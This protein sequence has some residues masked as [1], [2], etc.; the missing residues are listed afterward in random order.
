MVRR[1]AAEIPAE[2]YAGIAEVVVSPRTVRHPEREGIW[3]LGECIPLPGED[4]DP[5]H[6]QSRVVLYHGSFQALARETPDFDWE[7]EAWETLTHEVRHHVEWKARAPDLDAY[8]RAAEAN[9][10][11][12]DGEP[13]D[14]LFFR[15]GIPLPDGSYQVDDDVFVERVVAAAPHEVELRWRGEL[16][17]VPVP[18][19]ATL[20]AL[21]SV[22]GLAD[23]PSGE[24]VLVLRQRGGLLDLL[25]RRK[26]YE[27]RVEAH[28]RPG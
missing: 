22:D 1:Q 4:G 17:A 19:Q 27:A 13:Y 26:P 15:D 2:F 25:R 14:P 5:R 7:G 6:L 21:L 18:E 3:T 8:D 20:P 10:A 11:R 9:Y 28:P 23:P 12:Q 16:L 24:L